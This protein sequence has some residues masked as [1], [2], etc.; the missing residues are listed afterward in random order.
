MEERVEQKVAKVAKR[1]ERK[2]T[3]WAERG[4][5]A[6]GGEPDAGGGNRAGRRKGTAAGLWGEN[7]FG[8]EYGVPNGVMVDVR[9]STLLSL[10]LLTGRRGGGRYPVRSA[11]E[12]IG[13]AY[14]S[15]RSDAPLSHDFADL[16]TPPVV[17]PDLVLFGVYEESNAHAA[18]VIP[19]EQQIAADAVPVG[20]R[21]ILKHADQSIDVRAIL[22]SKEASQRP[23]VLPIVAHNLH[24]S[25]FAQPKVLRSARPDSVVRPPAPLRQHPRQED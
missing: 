6:G 15:S 21:G 20:F 12:R 11:K 7:L 23:V 9:T 25:I 4:L 24:R 10:S 22:E 5:A 3:L 8:I 19:K 18:F 2:R 13:R 14:A 17:A 1:E 16:L